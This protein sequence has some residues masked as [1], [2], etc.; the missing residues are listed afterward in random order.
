MAVVK[1]TRE[2]I[3]PESKE[4]W[5][6]LRLADITSTEISALFGCSPYMTEYELW[7]KK[8]GLLADS[9]EENERMKWG[10]RLQDPI[11][12]GVAADNNW[13]IRE[14]K[15]YIRNPEHKI[16]S[17]FDYV[18]VSEYGDEEAILEI[19]NVDSLAFKNGWIEHEDGEM[20]P[21][22]H[23][24]LQVQHQMIVSG[25][26]KCFIAALVGGNRAVILE[27]EKDPALEKQILK[28][29]D[30]FWAMIE[31]NISPKPDFNKDADSIKEIYS[32]AKKGKLVE[33]PQISRD[34]ASRYSCLTEQIAML[35]KEK[36]S[37]KSQ[38][39]MLM[40][41]AEKMIGPD[42]TVSAGLVQ[43][44]EYTVKPTSYRNFRITFKELI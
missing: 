19:K 15:E 37:I 42:F 13:L 17:S 41:D 26:N 22:L 32:T 25:I 44:G 5:L 23:I 16:G 28:K 40:G 31:K 36:E 9:F 18:V 11:A 7:H 38:M 33:A 14:K 21:P 29:A 34:L 3:L 8:K 30:V 27:R 12:Q 43:K 4:A 2:S 35:L 24:E 10:T 6:K 20:E 39:I 1:V